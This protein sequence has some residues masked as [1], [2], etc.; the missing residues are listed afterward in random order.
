MFISISFFKLVKFSSII[1]LKI[2]SEPY[3][4]ESSHFLFLLF[5]DLFFHVVT[6]FFDVLCL[7]LFRF[8]MSFTDILISSTNSSNQTF[9]LLSLVLC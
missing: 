3:I 8:K 9:S 2:C 1:L 5:L 6:Y 4:Y 7:E